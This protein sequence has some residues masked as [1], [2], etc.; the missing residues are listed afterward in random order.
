M[1]ALRSKNLELK[2]ELLE[3]VVLWSV[4]LSNL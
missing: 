4:C 2:C 1:D 3:F